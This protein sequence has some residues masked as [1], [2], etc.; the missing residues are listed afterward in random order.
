MFFG[1]ALAVLTTQRLPWQDGVAAPS[2]WIPWAA[3]LA[4]AVLL[5]VAFFLALDATSSPRDWDAVAAWHV[6]A[7]HLADA[8]TLGQP[9]FADPGVWHHSRDYPLLQPL[10]LASC[11]SLFGATT[12]GLLFPG[13]Y[14]LATATVGLAVH[15]AGRH[16]LV[17]TGTALAFGLTPILVDPTSGGFST[18]YAEAFLATAI[19]A[20]AAGLVLRDGWLLAAGTVLMVLLKPEGLI[21]AVLVV[22]VPWLRGERRLLL[23]A[24]LAFAVAAG[25]WLP[26]QLRLQ[27]AQVSHAGAFIW[28][29]LLTLSLVLALTQRW[30]RPER[31]P[32]WLLVVVAILAAVALLLLLK[33]LA[34]GL[35][36]Q[37][38]S[39]TAYFQDL[40]RLRD[41]LPRLPQILQGYVQYL[42]FVRKVGLLFVLLLL[43]VVC[44]RKVGPCPAPAVGLLLLLAVPCLAMPYL[45]STEENLAHQMRST[46]GRLLL[47]WLGA[48]WLLAGLWVRQALLQGQAQEE[49]HDQAGRQPQQ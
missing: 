31:R 4:I 38:G 49:P 45:L 14:L 19:T 1:I 13:L 27:H 25:L 21:Y 30:L 15:R 40:D 3:L 43:C 24:T 12:G 46:M 11:M 41:R 17:A 42:F 34:T 48:G 20:A 35:G 37:H 7:R 18:G 10:C 26:L 36:Q 5:L 44:Y 39:L 28:S 29:A 47:H 33:L 16:P 22:A 9:F 6:K 23:F 8:P 32:A 2:R